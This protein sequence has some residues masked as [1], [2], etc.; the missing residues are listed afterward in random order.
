MLIQTIFMPIVEGI[1]MLIKVS[2]LQATQQ[3]GCKGYTTVSEKWA[4]SSPVVNKEIQ[5]VHIPLVKVLHQY[6][7]N[8]VGRLWMSHMSQVVN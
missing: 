2:V 1:L 7:L 4:I 8:I 6:V 5:W 3:F